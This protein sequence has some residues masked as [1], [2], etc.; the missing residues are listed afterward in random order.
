MSIR[1]RVVLSIVTT[2]L[3]AVATLPAATV[4]AAASPPGRNGLL[5][6]IRFA[7]LYVGT[8]EGSNLHRLTATGG[9][10]D[11]RWSPDGTTIAFS[12][13]GYIWKIRTDGSGLTRLFAGSH[14]AWS[15]DGR[16]LIYGALDSDGLSAV[17]V[18]SLISGMITLIDNYQDSGGCP[19]E[20][21]PGPSGS[22]TAGGPVLY[23]AF[24]YGGYDSFCG[25]QPTDALV[26]RLA[27]GHPNSQNLVMTVTGY[28]R[29]ASVDAAPT[30][31]TFVFATD[32]GIQS[33]QVR[34]YLGNTKSHAK[35]RLTSASGVLTPVF[36]ADGA[37]VLYA[38]PVNGHWVLN[39]VWVKSGQVTR[40]L[41]DASQASVQP[42]H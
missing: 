15:P 1:V 20:Y 29:V 33:G 34:M 30:G 42:L 13:A 11:P 38:I 7:D 18:R 23:G 32:A 5:A 40:V 39:R 36:A 28:A 14:P 4:S 41:I 25:Q 26:Q 37:S 27:V 17:Y 3:V 24:E 6:F 2:V 10:S 8:L 19:Y 9:V 12:R 21:S 16:S 22:F 35:R 31:T